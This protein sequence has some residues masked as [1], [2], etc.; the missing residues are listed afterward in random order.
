M[1]AAVS[2][3]SDK[4]YDGCKLRFSPLP[5]FFRGESASYSMVIRFVERKQKWKA[6]RIRAMEKEQVASNESS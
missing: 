6:V 5:Q 1:T 2:L 3:A 4:E